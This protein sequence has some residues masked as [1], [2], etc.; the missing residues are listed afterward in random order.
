MSSAAT[1]S[2]RLVGVV[3]SAMVTWTIGVIPSDIVSGV[4]GYTREI[5]GNGVCSWTKGLE[6]RGS[7]GTRNGKH[8][9][10]FTPDFECDKG[11]T[12]LSI[13]GLLLLR[14]RVCMYKYMCIGV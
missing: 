1:L 9:P 2:T 10:S 8:T 7:L 5:K 12:L 6:R 3:E 14:S 4:C 13:Y 11:L